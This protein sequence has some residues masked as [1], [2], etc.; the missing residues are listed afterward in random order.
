VVF[1]ISRIEFLLGSPAYPKADKG[2]PRFSQ[3]T[4]NLMRLLDGTACPSVIRTKETL[5]ARRAFVS[6]EAILAICEAHLGSP[7]CKAKYEPDGMGGVVYRISHERDHY[8]VKVQ[9]FVDAKA[10]PSEAFF[11]TYFSR[12]AGLNVPSP[13]ILDMTAQYLSFPVL[14][15]QEL[16]GKS[17]AWLLEHG[18]DCDVATCLRRAAQALALLHNNTIF[19]NNVPRLIGPLED[20]LLLKLLRGKCAKTVW[21]NAGMSLP[22]DFLQFGVE[23]NLRQLRDFDVCPRASIGEWSHELSQITPPES[24]LVFLHGD[25]SLRNFLYHGGRLSGL[26]DGSTIIAWPEI[27]LAT[28]LVFVAQMGHLYQYLHEAELL[29]D[30]VEAYNA[31]ARH[32]ARDMNRLELLMLRKVVSRLATTR[33]INPQSRSI[34]ILCDLASRCVRHHALGPSSRQKLANYL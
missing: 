23:S 4:D 9:I 21:S 18:V 31:V 10:L 26:I 27:D 13:I 3:G 33:R 6:E 17:L 20:D 19:P 29:C 24:P 2:R 32:P 34:P 15:M 7:A 8:I 14:I 25:P 11:L 28:M 5:N 30:V 12:F 22:D 16:P 1:N